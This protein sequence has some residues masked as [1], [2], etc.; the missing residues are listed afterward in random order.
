MNY[1]SFALREK[2]ILSFGLSFTFMS[3]F[4]QTFL[5]SLF[6]PYFLKDF[7][8]NNATFGSLYSVATLVSAGLLPYLGKWI[9]DLP[10]R[11]YSQMVAAG[12]LVASITVALSWHVALLFV[13]LVLLRL[14]GQ[15]LSSHTAQ[16][17]MARYFVHQRGK[18]LSISSL[19]YPIGEGILPVAIA[20][21]LGIFSWRMTWGL[22]VLVIALLFIP[23]VRYTL[24]NR[25]Y[26]DV[27]ET[28]EDTQTNDSSWDVY[29]MLA[30]D[31]RIW[32]ITPAVLLP[33]FWATGLFL[34][35]VSIAEQLGW[36]A[37]L[38]ATAFVGFAASRVVSTI[39][40]GPV[41][42]YFSAKT[43]IPYYVVPFGMGLL[44]AYFHPGS[45]SAFA[46]ML[47]VGVTMGMG[48]NVKSALWAELYGRDIIGTV[49]SLFSSLMVLSTALCPIL[50]GWAIDNGI[51]MESII[52]VAIITIGIA[53]LMAYAAF[54]INQEEIYY[55]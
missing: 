42:D 48:S 53:T 35:Q 30:R 1:L 40:I 38:I 41:I 39:S 12:L 2:R 32:L 16:T 4:G 54:N 25:D 45:W 52:F 55:D 47:L 51:A 46:Y 44:F 15:G 28:E 7:S 14:S 31:Y 20:G 26:E 10:L 8:L 43:V 50:M 9:D 18:A 27:E 5:I 29:K 19:G 22:I 49:R 23:L 33:P 11:T 34:Y 6:V 13:G 24:N 21:L 36:S 37:T 3:S 17:A